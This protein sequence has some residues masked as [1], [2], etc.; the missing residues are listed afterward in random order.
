MT[1][2]QSRKDQAEVILQDFSKLDKKKIPVNNKGN[3]KFPD[4]Y[5]V[6]EVKKVI[7]ELKEIGADSRWLLKNG[8]VAAGML[9]RI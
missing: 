9:L 2:Q 3:I 4:F 6:E 5:E 7:N 8:F 1:G